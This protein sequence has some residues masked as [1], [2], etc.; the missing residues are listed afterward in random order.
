MINKLHNYLNTPISAAPLISFRLIFGALMVISAVRFIY[1]GWIEEQFVNPIFHFKYWGFEWVEPVSLTGFYF[2]YALLILSAIGVMLASGLLYRLA[3]I[4]LFLTF[5]YTE[6]IDLTYYLNHYYFVSLISLLLIFSPAHISPFKT[7]STQKVKRSFILILKIQI[8]IL[9]IYAGLAKINYD[10]LIEA[11]PL[12]IWLPAHS[13][14]PILGPLLAWEFTP[15]LFSWAGMLFDTFII[16]FLL[17]KSTRLYAYIAVIVF[18]TLNGILFQIGVFPIVMIGIVTIFFSN[19]WHLKFIH[20]VIP[21]KERS[22]AGS[23]RSKKSSFFNYLFILYV[24]FQ[25]IFPWRFLLYPG[26]L[27]WNEQ[28]YRFSWRVMLM[29][30]AG[31]AFFYVKDT[32]TGREGIVNN[33]DFLNVHQEKQMAMQPDMIL[34]FAHYLGDYYKRN[35]VHDPE[36]R[37]EVYVTLNGRPSQLLIDPKM[38][39]L[40]ESDTFAPKKWILPYKK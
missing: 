27:F 20:F 32:K 38:D 40:K 29:E 31:T 13:N 22:L 28:G 23:V 19:K 26:N 25:L 10:W 7:I 3:S 4:I 1:L 18:H 30:K 8:A 39:L 9:Y 37:A 6:L 15:Y 11:L 36:V 2:I 24:G 33:Q 12:K 17:K 16:L 14:L 5:T 34:Q 21:I 35:G